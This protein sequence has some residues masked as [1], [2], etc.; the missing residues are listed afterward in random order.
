MFAYRVEVEKD[1]NFLGLLI[2]KNQVKPESAEV[3]H[4]LKLA[5]LRPVMVTGMP[6]KTKT[7][8]HC[9]FYHNDL[10]CEIFGWPLY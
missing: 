6:P 2:M 1:M 10:F 3:I 8:L 9:M 4:I 5:N 7:L